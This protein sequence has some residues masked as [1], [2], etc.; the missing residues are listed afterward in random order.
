MAALFY[1]PET[2]GSGLLP[3]PECVNEGT[4]NPTSARKRHALKRVLLESSI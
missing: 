2:D 3:A 1:V 4:G